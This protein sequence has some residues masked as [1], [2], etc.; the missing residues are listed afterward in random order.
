MKPE[1]TNTI[2]YIGTD[3]KTI[4]LFESQYIAPNGISYNSYV[5][6]DE[7]I[8]VMDTVDKR[9]TDEWI[10]NLKNE[11][12]ERTPDYLVVQHLEPDHSGSMKAI[13]DLYP[14]IKIVCSAKAKAM[15]PQF[16]ELDCEIIAK[17]EG[18]TLELGSHTLNFVTAP[19]VHWPEVMISYESSEKVLFS[20]DAFGKFGALDADEGWSCEARRYYFN[21]VG[22][23]GAPV[24][25]V[26]KK[27]AALDIKTICPLH[28]PVLTDTIPEVLA[29]YNTW[30]SYEPEDEGVFIAY[31]SIHGNTAEAAHKMKEMLEEKGCPRVAIADLSRDDIA[32][33]VEDAFRHSTLLCMASSYDGGVFAPMSDFIHHLKSKAFQN[34]RV[35][36]VENASWAAS[37]ARTMKAEFEQMKNITFAENT[38]TIKTTVKPAD[39]EALDKLADEL[40]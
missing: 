3:D 32:E 39:L 33:C 18:D 14:D 31:A 20:A 26:L 23:Y 40:K 35:A 5:I 38:V 8:A 36:F 4:D 17:G 1:I 25:T 21:I 19:M 24:Q 7:K 22:K 30:S 13:V 34:R 15:M 10:E 28:G 16:A 37:A 9:K 12:G 6:M 29:L 2:K 11:L 27:A